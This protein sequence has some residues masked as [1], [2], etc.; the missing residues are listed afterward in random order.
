M[1]YRHGSRDALAV[2]A[3]AVVAC[4]TGPEIAC[5]LKG[6]QH[7]LAVRLSGFSDVIA[8]E[9]E[10]QSGAPVFRQQCAPYD[11]DLIMFEAFLPESVTVRVITASDTTSRNVR[12]VYEDYLPNGRRCAPVCRQGTVS[13]VREP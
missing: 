9:A 8:V 1:R 2:L 4:A 13:I 5:T 10:T 7:G 11:C 3:L 6:C 12:P